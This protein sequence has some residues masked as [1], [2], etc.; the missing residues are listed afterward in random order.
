MSM[1]TVKIAD[2]SGPALDWAVAVLV[3]GF[4][5]DR[6]DG[7]MNG[8]WVMSDITKPRR[9]VGSLGPLGYSPRQDWSQGGPLIN[10]H[11]V[12][13][14]PVTDD[15][16]MAMPNHDGAHQ[17][18]WEGRTMEFGPTPLTAA[19]RAIVAAHTDGDTVEV[20]AALAE[21]DR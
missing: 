4:R 18:Y 1:V 10:E 12:L 20:P 15:S 11:R 3:R 8:Y 21:G 16:W 9:K 19:M 7:A 6:L 14:S 5:V 13:L 17:D 2:L